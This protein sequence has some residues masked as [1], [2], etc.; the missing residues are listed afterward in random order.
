MSR[1]LYGVVDSMLC[2]CGLFL[3]HILSTV[4]WTVCCVVVDSFCVMYFLRCGGQYAVQL[5]TVF[6]SRTFYGVVDSMLCSCGLFL[7]H[8]LSTVWW[9]VCCVVLDCFCVTYFL[10]CGGQYAV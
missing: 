7:C 8:V 3:C 5:W 10:R 9:T 6:V 2:S 4:W 1:T